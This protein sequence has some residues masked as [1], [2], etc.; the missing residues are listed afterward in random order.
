LTT[1]A[2][3]GELNITS[4]DLATCFGNFKRADVIVTIQA[5]KTSL[6]AKMRN[7]TTA[8]VNSEISLGGLSVTGISY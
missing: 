2:A 1:I 4:S 8:G 6:N 3:N 7:T 5:A